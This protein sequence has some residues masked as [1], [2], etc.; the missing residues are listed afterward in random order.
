M[1]RLNEQQASYIDRDNKLREKSMFAEKARRKD[2]DDKY[3]ECNPLPDPED[4]KDLT[5]FITL[6]KEQQDANLKEC[7]DNCQVAENVIKTM[8]EILGNA[9]ANFK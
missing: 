5:T 1:K 9:I 4:E 2:L 3:L 7:A 8:Q 6:W